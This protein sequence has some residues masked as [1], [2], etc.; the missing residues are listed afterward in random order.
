MPD[1]FLNRDKLESIMNA[2]D[3]DQQVKNYLSEVL[4]SSFSDL[5]K[6]FEAQYREAQK[7]VSTPYERSKK[8]L[9]PFDVSQLVSLDDDVPVPQEPVVSMPPL[10]VF[11]SSVNITIKKVAKVAKSNMGVVAENPVLK[12]P[13]LS[14]PVVSKL[15]N[16]KGTYVDKLANV[17]AKKTIQPKPIRQ[18]ASADTTQKDVP[19]T[20]RTQKAVERRLKERQE[21]IQNLFKNKGNLS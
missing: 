7:A 9:Q 20:L 6:P 5:K 8:K 14:K 12:K 1:K 15:A 11:D 16:K 3:K 17:S 19:L 10:P 13:P 21:K 2:P 18:A 4:E